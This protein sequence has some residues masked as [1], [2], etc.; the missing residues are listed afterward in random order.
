MKNHSY[1]RGFVTG[2]ALAITAVCTLGAAALDKWKKTEVIPVC[3]VKG[4]IGGFEP[5]H[6]ETIG[7]RWKKDEAT[8]I[9][10]VS[11]GIGG[12]VPIHGETIGNNWKREQV[13]PFVLVKPDGRDFVAGG[14]L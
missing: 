7:H 10:E 12:F 4:V 11:T 13:K 6:G 3:P 14:R 2:F 8:P 5:I 1:F 9:C